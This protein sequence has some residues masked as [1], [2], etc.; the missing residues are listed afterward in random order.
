[1]ALP[2]KM[3]AVEIRD[4]SWK[5]QLRCTLTKRFKTDTKLFLSW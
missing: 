1:M 4:L 5:I 2:Q 3:A